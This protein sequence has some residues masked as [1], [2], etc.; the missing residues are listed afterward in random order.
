MKKIR[1][2]ESQIV[3]ILKLSDSDM[4]VEDI[5]RQNGLRLATYY[6]WKSKYGGMEVPDIKHLKELEDENTQLKKMFADVS[7]ENRAM[8][9]LFAKK[10]LVMAEK[11]E[12]TQHLVVCGLSV[13]REC[14]LISLNRSGYYHHSID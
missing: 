8:K 6:N 4:K 9:N 7:L 1:F 14:W 5:C 11:K 2:T 10:W 13:I 3:T 12:A